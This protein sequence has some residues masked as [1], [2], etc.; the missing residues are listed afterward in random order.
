MSDIKQQR[1]ADFKKKTAAKAIS[2]HKHARAKVKRFKLRGFRGTE[3]QLAQKLELA[4]KKR[5]ATGTNYPARQRAHQRFLDQALGRAVIEAQLV[6][7]GVEENPGPKHGGS[8]T[9]GR[10]FAK[11]MARVRRAL[12]SSD[13]GCAS[14]SE[15]EDDSQL[16]PA[17]YSA[18]IVN[19]E[20]GL[21]NG[22][23]VHRRQRGAVPEE[24]SVDGGKGPT[25]TTTCSPAENCPKV[26]PTTTTSITV[27]TA[28]VPAVKVAD[29][30]GSDAASVEI[31]SSSITARQEA[32]GSSALGDTSPVRIAAPANTAPTNATPVSAAVAAAEP[33][34]VLVPIPRP[35]PGILPLDGLRVDEDTLVRLLREKYPTSLTDH[36]HKARSINLMYD[37]VVPA[38]LDTRLMGDLAI[39]RVNRPVVLGFWDFEVP[40][41][42]RLSFLE[43]LCRL[44]NMEEKHLVFCPHLISSVVREYSLDVTPEQLVNIRPKMLRIPALP[45][46]A[47]LAADVLDGS[48]FVARLI[49]SARLNS[50]W[51]LEGPLAAPVRERR[52][53]GPL[54]TFGPQIAVPTLLEHAPMKPQNRL[55]RYPQRYRTLKI[56]LLFTCV[57]L[58]RAIFE[59]CRLV[60]SLVMPRSHWIETILL[61][62]IV[63]SLRGLLVTCLFL[64]LAYWRVWLLLLING[65]LITLRRWLQSLLKTGSPLR[66][67][68]NGVGTS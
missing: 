44:K 36:G 57:F 64:A 18:Y 22:L 68:P 10:N 6:Q 2:A 67:I 21:S 41:D 26:A 9:H 3:A 37:V 13:S 32:G 16:S 47:R 4:R 49:L 63:G 53:K 12:V 43:K 20:V 60:L 42:D 58:A 23:T 40:T 1:A 19:R 7:S 50:T 31:S 11:R 28:S 35:P 52:R 30:A 55:R 34:E 8:D 66:R 48:E 15:S 17:L 65:C 61:R 24:Q 39:P 46:D 59:S 56:A 54:A 45:L 14:P 38:E 5:I 27:T 62:C 25:T 29:T 51:S 33:T